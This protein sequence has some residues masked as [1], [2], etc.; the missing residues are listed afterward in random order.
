M[1]GHH[2][3]NTMD[4]QM[5][6]MYSYLRAIAHQLALSCD[7]Y[8]YISTFHLH[9]AKSIMGFSNHVK[10][11]QTIHIDELCVLV[12]PLQ[13]HVVYTHLTT[14]HGCILGGGGGRHIYNTN[15]N[16]S[17]CKPKLYFKI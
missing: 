17:P 4:G 13:D 10:I 12:S 8:S 7:V 2:I 1:G 3:H 11:G 16:V 5:S 14:C 9:L 6:H 15:I